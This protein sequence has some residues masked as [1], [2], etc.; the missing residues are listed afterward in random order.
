MRQ[1]YFRTGRDNPYTIYMSPTGTAREPGE[2]FIGSLPDP[3]LTA[4]AV[5]GMNRESCT[6]CSFECENCT[7]IYSTCSCITH[8]GYINHPMDT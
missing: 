4:L 8:V 1:F 6:R 2:K 7:L 5:Q 3:R